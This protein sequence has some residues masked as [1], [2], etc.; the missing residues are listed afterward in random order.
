MNRA[1]V[2]A[3]LWLSGVDAGRVKIPASTPM[4]LNLRCFGDIVEANKHLRIDRT[5]LLETFRAF[6]R[7]GNGYLDAEEFAALL[8]GDGEPLE[9]DEIATALQLADRN[10]DGR[11]DIA[12]FV[13]M[14]CGPVNEHDDHAG[15]SRSVEPLIPL[16]L[17]SR[18]D[19]HDSPKRADFVAAQMD[20]ARQKAAARYRL[21]QMQSS[22]RREREARDAAEAES[23][24][25]AEDA[26]FR[27]QLRERDL[28]KVNKNATCCVVS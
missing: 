21:S 19:A 17:H 23:Q 10:G 25:H 12:E 13:D 28:Q 8:R 27:R 18:H 6:D 5:S 26:E 1:C 22:E 20:E 15:K 7:D 24:K 16:Q 3:A 4:K 9:D 11:L 2:P 14:L